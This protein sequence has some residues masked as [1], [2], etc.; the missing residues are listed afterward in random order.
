MAGGI[1]KNQKCSN[2]AIKYVL[3]FY[4]CIDLCMRVQGEFRSCMKSTTTWLCY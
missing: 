1:L 2:L 3:L 4:R